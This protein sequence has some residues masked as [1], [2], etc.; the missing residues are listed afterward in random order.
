MQFK[1]DRSPLECQ[2]KRLSNRYKTEK[3]DFIVACA[4]YNIYQ[5]FAV[6]L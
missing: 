3:V 2:K 6:V 4:C 5:I 1:Y